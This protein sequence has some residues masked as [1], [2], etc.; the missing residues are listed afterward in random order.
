[1]LRPFTSVVLAW[2]LPL[3]C[4]PMALTGSRRIAQVAQAVEGT[5]FTLSRSDWFSILRAA[6]GHEV[7]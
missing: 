1:L 3:P 2:I 7:A 5:Q 4:R 6:R